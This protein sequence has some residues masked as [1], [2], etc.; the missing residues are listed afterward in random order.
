MHRVDR[1]RG[2]TQ[3]QRSTPRH[4]L[5]PW[6]WLTALATSGLSAAQ[7]T[8]S[9]PQAVVYI[10]DNWCSGGYCGYSAW[11]AFDSA[12]TQALQSSGYVRP[13]RKAEGANLIMKAGINSIT[14]G[15][16]VCLPLVGCLSAK[17]VK[18]SLEVD[19]AASG[20]VIWQDTCEGTSAGYSSWGYGWSS[21]NFS[22]DDS[23]A[24]A[25]CAGKLVQKLNASAALK[26]YLTVAAG[27]PLGT[28]APVQTLAVQAAAAPTSTASTPSDA[29]ASGVVGLLGGALQALSFDDVNALFTSDP[30]NPVSVR[31]INAAASAE[32][33]TSAKTLKFSAVSGEDAGIYRLVG[34]TYS[35]PDGSEHFAQLAVSGPGPLNARSGPRIVYLSA[36][37]PARSATPALDALSKNVETLLADV[38]RALKL[39]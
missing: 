4:P 21:V 28:A 38:R 11:S 35:L 39:P 13:V 23:K 8:Y 6:L 26:P 1:Q 10:G 25:D 20:T 3:L 30:I 27:A 29:Q 22:S 34:L 14:G 2:T 37:N 32:T 31:A 33:L 24:A 19:D 17:S 18:A 12:M 5:T 15:G 7:G 9:G 36:F 16:G